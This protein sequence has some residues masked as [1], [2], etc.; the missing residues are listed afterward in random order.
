MKL[1][2]KLSGES[3]EAAHSNDSERTTA[4]READRDSQE[5]SAGFGYVRYTALRFN[6][7]ILTHFG[8]GAIVR[9]CIADV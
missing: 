1:Q 3:T 4:D 6:R 8:S 9:L 5:E 7:Q 2:L